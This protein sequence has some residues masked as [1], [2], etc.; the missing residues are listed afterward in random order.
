M[1]VQSKVCDFILGTYGR[2]PWPHYGRDRVVQLLNRQARR[3]WNGSRVIVRRGLRLETDL[4][5]DDVGWTLYSYGCLDYWDER[6]IRKLL[7]PGAVCLDI[8]AHIGYYSLLMS[9]WV[10]PSGKVISFEPMPYT[11]SF[12]ATNLQRNRARNV[13]AKQTAVGDIAGYVQMEVADNRR[14]GWSSVSESGNTKVSCT[15][16]DAEIEA[17]R[18]EMV[19]FIK[20]DVEGYELNVLRGCEQTIKQLRPKIMFEVNERALR[21]HRADLGVLEDFFLSHSYSLFRATSEGSVPI[22]SRPLSSF[23][24]I[25]ALPL[26]KLGRNR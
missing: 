23:F 20:I 26:S 15:S 21:Q 5:V 10:G 7:H 3:E 14:L 12:L 4:R 22:R 13:V 1:E 19:D 6:I 16:V 17:N 2:L 11:Y 25:F 18:L 24:N 8:G 9:R